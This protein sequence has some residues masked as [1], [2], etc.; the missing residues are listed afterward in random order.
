MK[1]GVLT[2]HDAINYGAVLQ[3]VAL[4][5]TISNVC[6]ST[7]EIVDYRCAAI[8]NM[9]KVADNN[10]IKRSVKEIYQKVKRSFFR[11]FV[12]N[13][14]RM[15]KAVDAKSIQTLKDYYDGWVVGSD[16]VWNGNITGHDKN[17]L[18]NFLENDKLRI[19]YAAS[20]GNYVI[21]SEEMSL[22]EGQLA[23]FSGVSVREPIGASTIRKYVSGNVF[24]HVDPTLLL[25]EKEWTVMARLPKATKKYIFIYAAGNVEK[26]ISTAK[27]LSKKTGMKIYYMGNFSIPEGKK[28]ALVTPEKWLGYMK[29][30]GY[31]LTNSFHGTVFS[32]IFNKQF[33]VDL[34]KIELRDGK[35]MYHNDRADNLVNLL[36]LKNRII[37]NVESEWNI[38]PN[39]EIRD[40]ILSIEKNRAF[41]YLK[42]TLMT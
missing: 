39:W 20:L 2:F 34:G 1:I 18:L 24:V 37:D 40:S 5:K 30:A 12:H 35:T 6:R 9:Y 19:S 23:A 21:P 17:Y 22:F 36:G 29:G 8:D 32:I 28:L 16:Q 4:C 38:V 14:C 25:D 41:E 42:M 11:R 10:P 33:F 13:N 7:C 3:T 15:T 27:M 31:V 26:I